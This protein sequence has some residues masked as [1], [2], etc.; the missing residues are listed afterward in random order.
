MW[1]CRLTTLNDADSNL[2]LNLNLNLNANAN[3]NAN[4]NMDNQGKCSCDNCEH[5]SLSGR[6]LNLWMRPIFGTKHACAQ[7]SK[8]KKG[9]VK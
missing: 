8:I 3:A 9:E 1:T 5:C 7:H 6:Y 2:N 4:A